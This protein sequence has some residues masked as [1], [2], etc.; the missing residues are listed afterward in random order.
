[1]NPGRI[2]P[3][4]SFARPKSR[5]VGPEGSFV[6]PEGSFVGPEDQFGGTEGRFVGPEGRF[7]GPKRRF[8]GPEGSFVGPKDPFVGPEGSLV[9][10]EGPFVGPEESFVGPTAGCSPV[11]SR[12]DALTFPPMRAS[13]LAVCLLLA[14]LR[15]VGAEEARLSP[16]G[17]PPDWDRL[18]YSG[19]LAADEADR[20][21]STVYAPRGAAAD[22]ILVEPMGK[23]KEH[24]FISTRT[25]PDWEW[26]AVEVFLPSEDGLGAKSEFFRYWRPRSDI[27]PAP[28][29]P[30]RPLAGIKI[31]LDPGHL[32]GAFARLEERWFAIGDAAPITEGDL[33][34]RVAGMLA[35]RLRALGA[36]V[37][38][39]RERAEPTTDQRP[40]DFR[41]LARANLAARGI[42]H[43]PEDFRDSFDPDRFGTVR[44]ESEHLFVRA[45]IR[46]RARRVNEE[47]KPDLAVCL[48]FNAEPWGDPKEPTLVDKNHFHVLVNGCYSADELA[49]DD[50][51]FQML[52]KLLNGSHPEE[53]AAA[54][55]IAGTVAAATGLPPYEY[56][57]PN[58]LRVGANPYVW[59]R[60]LLA[61]RIFEC[62]TVYLEPYVMNSAEVFARVQAGDYE[63]EREVAGKLRPSIFRE[64]A[65]SVTAGVVAHFARREQ[66][67]R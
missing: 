43:P 28:A 50:V 67:G 39:T 64:Y 10:A 24:G 3:K 20:L 4:G 62:P 55:T 35:E 18:F 6:R 52:V 31:T 30:D 26:N 42:K 16:L 63:G 22:L 60:N 36:T 25:G 56:T 38:L 11:K 65:D 49:D 58:A 46:A 45:D 54:E 47:F 53:L 29:D 66:T 2:P 9:G 1:M 5:F 12:S 7:V 15:P 27:P 23:N 61:N 32:G 40:A 51:R 21:L 59:A 8:V 13:L 48:H 44:W 17:Q 34:L 41:D 57:R 33:T 14:L 19:N 37:F